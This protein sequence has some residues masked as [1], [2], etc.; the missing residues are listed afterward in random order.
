MENSPFIDDKIVY[1]S[2][3]K[4]GKAKLC[5][6]QTR[7]KWERMGTGKVMKKY[8]KWLLIKEPQDMYIL[9][10]IRLIKKTQL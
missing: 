4:K 2:F 5:K 8:E 7:S 10:E 1:Y 6:G 9:Y 3:G